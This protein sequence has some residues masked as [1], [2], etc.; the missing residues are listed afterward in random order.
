M[1]KLEKGKVTG[2]QTAIRELNKVDK[3]IVRQLRKDMKSMLSPDAKELAASVPATPPPISGFAN[4]TG[5]TRWNGAK[6]SVSVTP[7]RIRK[8]KDVHPIVTIK[9]TGE[10]DSVGFDVAEMAGLRNLRWSASQTK[11]STRNGQPWQRSHSRKQG[12]KLVQSLTA[13]ATFKFKGGR[14][15]YGFFL[16]QRKGIEKKAIKVINSFAKKFNR[17]VSK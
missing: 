1:I 3:G 9:L 13:S 12:K 15:A 6:G 16:R 11:P 14:F 7:S 10:G 4:H 8:G 17:K 5:R 2:L